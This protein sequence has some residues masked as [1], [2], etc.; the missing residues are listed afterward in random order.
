MKILAGAIVGVLLLGKYASAVSRSTSSIREQ[1]V[2]A[3]LLQTIALCSAQGD[4]DDFQQGIGISPPWGRPALSAHKH[5]SGPYIS[6]DKG[7]VYNGDSPACTTP[8]E[9]LNDILCVYVY[10]EFHNNRGLAIFTTPT[11]ATEFSQRVKSVSASLAE[12]SATLNIPSQHYTVKSLPKRGLGALA[13]NNTSPSTLLTQT[14]PILLVHS[15]NNPTTFDRESHLRLAI[16]LLPHRTRHAFHSLARIYHNPS[17]SHQDTVKA[18]TFAIDIAGSQH[19]AL[20]PE[21]SRFNHDCAP[22]AMY[23]VDSL[24]LTHT[25]HTTRELTVDEEITISYLD[26]FSPAASRKAYLQDA[27]GFECTCRRCADPVADDAKLAE[28]RRL[29][30]ILGDWDTQ[31]RES[32]SGQ[33][34]WYDYTDLAEELIAL[35][36]G[37]GLQ[38][39]MNTAYGHAALA[40]NSVGE[41]GRAT[42]YARRALEV[43]RIRHGTKKG[44]SRAVG[45]W[46]EFLEDGA[47]KHWSW[48]RRMG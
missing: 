42:M 33:P 6:P 16:S 3:K 31:P 7:L 15:D 17:V 10:P 1:C 39:F 20:F 27:F 2:V 21:P 14:T 5:R 34:Q 24:L 37:M 22:N 38:G 8:L 12:R 18:N 13:L 29:E 19:L 46:E 28:I 43:A 4:G 41:S 32:E 48:R 44:G 25:V 30:A 11:L 40:Y 45:V 47:W 26:P 35:Y 23:Q 36:E 9:Y